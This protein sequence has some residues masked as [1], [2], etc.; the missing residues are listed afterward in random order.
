MNSILP[1]QGNRWRGVIHAYRRLLPV[2]ARTPVVSLNENEHVK[3]NLPDVL[4]RWHE[5]GSTERSRA[6]TDQSFCV[7]K[8]NIVANDYDLSI[9]RYKEVVHEEVLYRAPSEIIADLI[10][11]EDE[12]RQGLADLDAMLG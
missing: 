3:N 10:V 7:P 11:L 8:A 9:N 6:H 1:R 12:I 2:T 5:R 4:A